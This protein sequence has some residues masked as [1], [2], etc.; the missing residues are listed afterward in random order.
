MKR[1]D[2]SVRSEKKKKEK[3]NIQVY[4]KCLLFPFGDDSLL[5]AKQNQ[6][7][8]NVGAMKDNFHYF[9]P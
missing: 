7:N 4:S 3:R 6:T 2:E 5:M 9:I 8:G 1:Y